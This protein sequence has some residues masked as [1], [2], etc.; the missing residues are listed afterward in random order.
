MTP[1]SVTTL[2]ISAFV[3]FNSEA[4]SHLRLQ[5]MVQDWPQQSGRASVLL[6]L[7][8]RTLGAGRQGP[9]TTRRTRRS[10]CLPPVSGAPTWKSVS[11]ATVFREKNYLGF[12]TVF[13]VST[14][15]K[16]GR[17]SKLL[18]RKNITK[19]PRSGLHTRAW[20]VLLDYPLRSLPQT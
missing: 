17:R 3:Q 19:S 7:A 5:N 13:N 14:E 1:V 10:A 6:Q 11:P 18:L 8:P 16:Y 9:V 20:Y 4:L 2:L 12:F 15:L